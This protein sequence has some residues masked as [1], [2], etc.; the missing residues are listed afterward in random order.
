MD[1]SQISVDER[2]IADVQRE[3]YLKLRNIAKN[4]G[5]KFAANLYWEEKNGKEYLMQERAGKIKVV[6]SRVPHIEEFYQSYTSGQKDV[7][8]EIIALRQQIDHNK[9]Q[10]S[11]STISRVPTDAALILRK[12]EKDSLLGSH[13]IISGL[14]CIYAYET[15][16]NVRFKQ[17]LQEK[18]I[19]NISKAAAKSLVL[20]GAMGDEKKLLKAA[21]QIDSTYR[22]FG[23]KGRYKL[24]N[25]N[26]F[27]VEFVC[28]E[29]VENNWMLEVP[30]IESIAFCDKGLPVPF[31][32]LAPHIFA[33]YKYW[34]AQN[35]QDKK[36]ST[37]AEIDSKQAYAIT[38]MVKQ[39]LGKCILEEDYT[40]VPNCITILKQQLA[41]ETQECF[42]RTYEL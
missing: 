26:N 29:N 37:R 40:S 35:H 10:I 15:H 31:V 13:F 23:S 41:T 32:C 6:G 18:D 1:Y 8:Q 38:D 24:T 30:R 14:Q 11:R 28:S 19:Y 9:H 12:L 34:Q 2:Q 5:L 7:V 22:I 27:S 3:A 33:L 4:E 20:L 25:R 39:E 36:Q 42:G 17:S 16:A 21:Q